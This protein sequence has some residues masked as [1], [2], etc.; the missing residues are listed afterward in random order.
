[1]R[2]VLNETQE[3]VSAIKEAMG[4][5]IDVKFGLSINNLLDDEIMVSLIA[6]HFKDDYD[7]NATPKEIR[8]A[9]ITKTIVQEYPSK[10]DIVPDFLKELDQEE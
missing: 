5:A 2:V 6:S 4:D 3:I 10:E 9:V 8:E 7:F 1:P